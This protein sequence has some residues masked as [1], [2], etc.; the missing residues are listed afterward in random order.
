MKVAE[1][2]IYSDV[3]NRAVMR[4]PGRKFPGMLVQGDNLYQLCLQADALCNELRDDPS[5]AFESANKIRNALQD[6]LSHYR[7]ALTE[8]GIPLPFRE[9]PQVR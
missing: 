7:Q 8:H 6:Y 5:A 3:T 9:D 2:E 1:V 4:H